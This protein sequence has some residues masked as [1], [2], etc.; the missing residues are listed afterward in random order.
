[1]SLKKII[2]AS[3]HPPQKKKKQANI[4]CHDNAECI[5]LCLHQAFL[6]CDSV[7]VKKTTTTT[8]TLKSK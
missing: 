2:G 6:L 3:K 1:M 5:S 8:T 7:R 4:P